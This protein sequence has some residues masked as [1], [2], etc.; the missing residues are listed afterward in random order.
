LDIIR[1]EVNVKS[2]VPSMK[3]IHVKLDTT[4][5]PELIKEGDDRELARAVADARKAEGFS[6]NDMV[7]TEIRSEGKYSATL[8]TGP[9]RFNLIRDAA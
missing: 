6:P 8:S 4:L 5:T 7:R 3:D 2:V 9:V 1:D